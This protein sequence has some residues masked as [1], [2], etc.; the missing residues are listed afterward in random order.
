MLSEFA[1]V[2]ERKV[3]HG[4]VAHLH[5]AVCALSNLGRCV[6]LQC[7]ELNRGHP[8]FFCQSQDKLRTKESLF[9]HFGPNISEVK[10]DREL[11]RK[12]M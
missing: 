11:M 8:A 1:E 9:V 5:N 4:Q 10:S 12:A 7:N 3:W 6:L 2:F